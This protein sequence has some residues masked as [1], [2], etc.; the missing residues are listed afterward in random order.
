MIL[1]LAFVV[2]F[3]W[4]GSNAIKPFGGKCW[5]K[6]LITSPTKTAYANTPTPTPSQQ[7]NHNK[8]LNMQSDARRNAGLS[9]LVWDYNLANSAKEYAQKLSSLGYLTHSGGGEQMNLYVGSTSCTDAV[10]M[11]LDERKN[12]HGQKI[13]APSNYGHFTQILNPNAR[14]VGC[15]EYRGYVA[16]RYDN[17]Q[18][19]GSVLKNY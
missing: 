17:I 19:T 13:V 9:A 4:C 12:Y 10:T 18:A 3:V 14:K 2:V 15:G 1:I 16:C 8:C 5:K 6:L 11:W 7:L